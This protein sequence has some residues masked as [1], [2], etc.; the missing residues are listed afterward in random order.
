M[1]QANKVKKIKNDQFFYLNRWVDK[2][3]FRAFVYDAKNAEKLAHSYEEYLTL[4]SSGIWFAEKQDVSVKRKPKNATS[5]DS[6]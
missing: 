4:T 2:A 3:H 5:S 6:K 1:D